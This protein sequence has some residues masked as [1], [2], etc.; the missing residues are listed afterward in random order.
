M[1]DGY[2]L[3]VP[4]PTQV[5]QDVLDQMMLPVVPHYGRDWTAYYNE[6]LDLLRSVFRPKSYCGRGPRASR[7]TIAR[8]FGECS[9]FWMPGRIDRQLAGNIVSI[10]RVV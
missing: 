9:V 6:T 7:I 3:M 8:S 1:L 5:R 2:Q 4:G 10:V